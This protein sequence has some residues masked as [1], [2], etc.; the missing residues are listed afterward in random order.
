MST[1]GGL[2]QSHLTLIQLK[3]CGMNSKFIR[4]EIKPTTKDELVG[5]ILKFWDTVTVEKC[6]GYI[7]HLKKVIPKVIEL[8][9]SATGY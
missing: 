2:L 3:I 5:G 6:N 1:G 4:R 9:G 8:N 7:N